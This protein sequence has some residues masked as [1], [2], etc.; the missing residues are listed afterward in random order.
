MGTTK[1]K[2]KIVIIGS[3]FVGSSAAFALSMSG[4]ASEIV[5]VDV[6]REKAMGEAMDL[7]HGLCFMGQMSISDGD[8][9]A[10]KGADIIL[11]TAG[12]GRKPGESRLDLA[13][14]N[15][16]IIKDIIPQI[17]EH[18]DGGVF[19]VVSN[20]V[21]VLTYLIQKLSGLPT[22]KVIGS[23]T[24][25]DSAR[26]RYQISEHCG[27]DV[28]NVHG[29]I[30][31]EHGDS[32]V[33]AWSAT[34]IA[35][36]RM[37]EACFACIKKCGSIGRE[38]IF[39]KVKDSG[40]K[41]IKYKGA[42]FYGIAIS[43]TRICEAILKDQN[44]ILTVGSV[45]EGHYGVNDVALSIPSVVNLDGIKSIFDIPLNEDEIAELQASAA[46]IKEVID[47]VI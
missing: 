23:G 29:Y 10:V 7:N 16:G 18:Y 12:A 39:A 28:K 27:V 19:L 46:K 43:I 2:G 3:G 44:S 21:D 24:V 37:D 22:S 42:T 35:G 36:K 32:E 40:A 25:L 47:Q 14:K 13:K 8:Y 31:G 1:S 34:H 6:N 41:I 20:P 11:V 9:S 30:I 38:E 15:A 5:L 4:L 26:F 45:I 33:P 17:M